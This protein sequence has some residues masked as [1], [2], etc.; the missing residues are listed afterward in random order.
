MVTFL[1]LI[2]VGMAAYQIKHLC[3][4]NGNSSSITNM[5]TIRN[6]NNHINTFRNKTFRSNSFRMHTIRNK[7]TRD[8]TETK[9]MD[10]SDLVCMAGKGVVTVHKFSTHITN[11]GTTVAQ[12]TITLIHA[13]GKLS[14]L[15]RNAGT[16]GVLKR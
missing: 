9:C 11:P 8:K 3:K 4:L 14:G 7:T 1:N 15:I 16:A 10:S 2:W 13:T 5:L 6:H 12:T